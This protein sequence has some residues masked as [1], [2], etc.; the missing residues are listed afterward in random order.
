MRKKPELISTKTHNQVEI[1][2][3]RLCYSSIEESESMETSHT[4]NS[5]ISG[6]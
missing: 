5:V 2:I 4:N 6:N 3:G 1:Q